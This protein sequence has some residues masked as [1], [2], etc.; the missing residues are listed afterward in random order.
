MGLEGTETVGSDEKSLAS[1]DCGGNSKLTA[2]SV[3]LCK[4][5]DSSERGDGVDSS[6]ISGVRLPTHTVISKKQRKR[7]R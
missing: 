2:E 5:R 7:E 6:S 3:P 1:V 4:G